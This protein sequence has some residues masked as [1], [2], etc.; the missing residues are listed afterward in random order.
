MKRELAAVIGDRG[1][2]IFELAVTDYS[3][4][5]RPLFRPSFLGDKW[6]SID[7]YVEL[8]G[9]PDC[10]PAMFV[11]V[12]ST[13]QPLSAGSHDIEISLG[14]VKCLS[15]FMVPGPTYL[16]GVHEPTRRAFILA[17]HS[18]PN[19]G[20]YRIPLKNELTSENLRL[21]YNEVAEFWKKHP[22]KPLTSAFAS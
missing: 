12:K 14:K 19:R 9:V 4:F 11:Q 5:A 8:L 20:I 1:E 16:V 15:L 2:S 6:P 7:Y 17:I 18:R 13:A 21:L 10:R 3:R 22:L